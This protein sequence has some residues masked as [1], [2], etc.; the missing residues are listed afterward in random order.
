MGDEEL[1]VGR[2]GDVKV[3]V[4]VVD[5]NGESGVVCVDR[6]VEKFYGRVRDSAGKL[7]ARIAGLDKGEE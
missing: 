5:R 2:V 4:S 6:D 7:K 1:G 3:E